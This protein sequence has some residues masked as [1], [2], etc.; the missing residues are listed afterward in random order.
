M[1]TFQYW[2]FIAPIQIPKTDWHNFYHAWM[3]VRMILLHSVPIIT[4][5]TEMYISDYTFIRSH[6]V[7]PCGLGFVYIPINYFG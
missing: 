5:F 1:A 2:V 6:W 3:T 7:L 4:S